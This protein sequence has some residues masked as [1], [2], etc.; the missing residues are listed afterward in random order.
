[1]S[2]VTAHY[3]QHFARRKKKIYR[4][5]AR[6]DPEVRIRKNI[7]LR[8]NFL[9]FKEISENFYYFKLQS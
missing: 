4:K 2:F 7:D 5:N 3:N 1:M 9:K 8:L 6:A